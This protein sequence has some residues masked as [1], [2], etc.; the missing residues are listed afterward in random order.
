VGGGA[1]TKENKGEETV[2][3]RGQA[4]KNLKRVKKRS[5]SPTRRCALIST[6]RAEYT[7]EEA[8]KG[9]SVK[10]R[11]IHR[12]WHGKKKGTRRARSKKRCG[13]VSHR[14]RGK[15]ENAAKRKR[16]KERDKNWKKKLKVQ[17]TIRLGGGGR[18]TIRDGTRNNSQSVEKDLSDL[19]E[20]DYCWGT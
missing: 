3:T 19:K 17:T 16:K 2:P 4:K 1:R 20:G 13:Q 11:K 14:R 12:L 10:R 18:K 5:G 6:K 8:G 7:F 15:R 9:V